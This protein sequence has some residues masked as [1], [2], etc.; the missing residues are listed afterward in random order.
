VA[1]PP[2]P[3]NGPTLKGQY[4][5]SLSQSLYSQPAPITSG[6]VFFALVIK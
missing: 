5:F 1:G 3:A 2:R 6:F 4:Q